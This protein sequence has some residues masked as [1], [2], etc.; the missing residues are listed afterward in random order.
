MSSRDPSRPAS[1][2]RRRRLTRRERVVRRF[3]AGV[4]EQGPVL[5]RTR[6][7]SLTLVAVCVGL[8][9]YLHAN[10]HDAASA[11]A[12]R[13]LNDAGQFHQ[14]L[15]R[16]QNVTSFPAS[17]DAIAARVAALAGLG[18]LDRA[19]QALRQEIRLDPADSWL[20]YELAFLYRAERRMRPALRVMHQALVL[21]PKLLVP[22]QLELFAVPPPPV[23]PV[24]G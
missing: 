7:F 15:G 10:Q 8:A 1:V 21:N 13:A 24:A 23:R 18:R 16:A 12:A 5:L 17:E 9:L 3:K 22:G 4:A 6:S 19:E 20:Y 2:R 14:A 11:Q